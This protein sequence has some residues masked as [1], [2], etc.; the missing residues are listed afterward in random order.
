M[1]FSFL[2]TE[3]QKQEG[4]K[5][6]Q[7]NMQLYDTPY[8]P[9]GSGVESDSESVVSQRLRESKLPQDDDR[10]ADEYDQ[11]WEWNKVTIPALA[12]RNPRFWPVNS[13]FHSIYACLSEKSSVSALL[14]GEGWR[15]WGLG[16]NLSKTF[17]GSLYLLQKCG[18]LHLLICC[19]RWVVVNHL[20]A[21]FMLVNPLFLSPLN[22]TPILMSM[23]QIVFIVEWIYD[24]S[25]ALQG[26]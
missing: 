11:P 7:K 20:S 2:I 1:Q 10:P 25:D 15:E 5:S 23:M 24:D 8:E 19:F 13:L 6:H 21:W 16:R 3:F 12:G 18:M 4:T 22:L 9:E 14:K 26:P 17:V